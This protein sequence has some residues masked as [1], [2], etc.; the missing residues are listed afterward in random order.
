M[1][2]RGIP[3]LWHL[4]ICSLKSFPGPKK[5]PLK[6]QTLF[7]QPCLPTTCTTLDPAIAFPEHPLR[8]C[9]PIP[10]TL[11][12]CCEHSSQEGYIP[13]LMHEKF[14]SPDGFIS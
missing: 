7:S 1:R 9:N 4:R 13:G 3:G 2:A 10:K 5:S 8:T 11:P 12:S 6:P 14:P